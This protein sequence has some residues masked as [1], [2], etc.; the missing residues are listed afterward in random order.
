MYH[1]YDIYIQNVFLV[2]IFLC[3]QL[4]RW[5]TVTEGVVIYCDSLAVL[6]LTDGGVLKNCIS[7]QR[8]VS[9]TATHLGATLKSGGVG[10]G[11]DSLGF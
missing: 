4:S 3:A 5:G 8:G 9:F 10:P 1:A 7:E 2:A 11:T 6:V